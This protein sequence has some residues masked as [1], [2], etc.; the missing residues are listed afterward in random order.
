M[1]LS[2]GVCV[3]QLNVDYSQEAPSRPPNLGKGRKIQPGQL[4][5]ASVLDYMK[6]NPEYTPHAQLYD[7]HSWDTFRGTGLS[8]NTQETTTIPGLRI[9]KDS[10]SSLAV[11]TFELLESSVGDG[12]QPSKHITKR[13]ETLLSLREFP[14]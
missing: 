4:I 10:H 5:H 6:D 2:D 1:Q 11:E 3:S 9:E 12:R 7:G 14:T 8:G 13:L